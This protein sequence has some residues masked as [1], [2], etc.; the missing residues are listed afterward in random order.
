MPQNCQS[1][2]CKILSVQ[3]STSKSCTS[4]SCFVSKS[5]SERGLFNIKQKTFVLFFLSNADP[6]SF[7][8]WGGGGRDCSTNRQDSTGVVLRKLFSFLSALTILVN[9]NFVLEDKW[10]SKRPDIENG[11][12]RN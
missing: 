10:K 7:F 2:A 9:S 5:N 1:F 4:L 8:F 3:C 11:K 6:F 12:I